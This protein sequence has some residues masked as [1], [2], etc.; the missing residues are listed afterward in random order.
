M[1][2]VQI[3]ITG[4]IEVFCKCGGRVKARWT[5]VRVGGTAGDWRGVLEVQP[6][7]TCMQEA[8]EA[9]YQNG[10]EAEGG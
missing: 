8:T 3:T 6:C 10:K 5:M 4:K 2:K 1:A 7:K 9:G